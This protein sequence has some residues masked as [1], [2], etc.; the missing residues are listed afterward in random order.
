VVFVSNALKPGVYVRNQLGTPG[1]EEYSERVIKF[2]KLCSIILSYVRHIFQGEA[3]DFAR[4]DS[5]PMRPPGYETA[6]VSNSNCSE[7]QIET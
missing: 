3:K 1:G 5:T 4:R 6:G 7:G 2:F